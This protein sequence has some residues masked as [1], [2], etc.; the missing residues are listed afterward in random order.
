MGRQKG[1]TGPRKLTAL[2]Q[3]LSTAGTPKGKVTPPAAPMGSMIATQAWEP[4]SLLHPSPSQLPS[5][6]L[7]RPCPPTWL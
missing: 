4:V 7:A 6:G 3:T 5:F 2:L 1:N